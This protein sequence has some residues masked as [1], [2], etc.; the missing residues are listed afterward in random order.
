MLFVPMGDA[1][2]GEGVGGEE[3]ASQLR[4]ALR[5][6]LFTSS[7]LLL[8]I[9]MGV[10]ALMMRPDSNFIFEGGNDAENV[11]SVIEGRA[12]AERFWW[13]RRPKWT[14]R[15]KAWER[16]HILEPQDKENS[17]RNDEVKADF[18]SIK[19]VALPR[20]DPGSFTL[21][22]KD[23]DSRVTASAQSAARAQAA[24]VPIDSVAA[25]RS[26]SEIGMELDDVNMDAVKAEAYTLPEVTSLA[27][28]TSFPD[29]DPAAPSPS[30]SRAT[31]S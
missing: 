5:R 29:A 27:V 10:T 6:V 2:A 20:V 8:G 11:N 3:N 16:S 18:A 19:P 4:P 24:S 13:K 7:L 22:P 31:V 12:L 14:E 25:V 26:A 30:P 23:T 21:A 15:R 1:A 17:G 9:T 28:S